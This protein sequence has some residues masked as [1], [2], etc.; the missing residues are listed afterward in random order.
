[1]KSQSLLLIGGGHSHAI[2]LR[3]WAMRYRAE[4]RLKLLSDVEQ[5]PY[6]GMLPGHVAGF[7]THQETHIDLPQLAE[8]SHAQLIRDRAVGLDLQKKQVLCKQRPPIPFDYLSV[9]IGST[10][11]ISNVS[12]AK[13]YAVPAK[14]VPI[15]LQHWNQF[16][17]TVESNPDQPRNLAIVGGGAGGVELALNM[18]QRLQQMTNSVSIHLLQ[19]GK[20]LLPQHGKW[21]RR[22]LQQLLTQRGI[23]LHLGEEVTEVFPDK[24]ICAS[25]M[26]LETEIVFW[27]TQATAPKWIEESGLAT[28]EKG[29][30]LVNEYLQ[31]VS[32]PFVFAAGDIA[33]IQ[34]YP[35]PKAGVFAVRQGK[36][37]FENLQRTILGKPLKPYRPQASYL[38]LIGTGDKS[39]I[40]SWRNLGFHHPL[41]WR[42]K[43]RIDRQFMAKF[44]N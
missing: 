29:F 5:T 22:K 43:D 31:S 19:R 20:A 18:Q 38:S 24:I 33:T 17:A 16:L 6:S 10:P 21:V 27:V 44:S 12:G 2:L 40:A 42:W 3:E 13:D 41:L 26:T 15:F 11:A 23:Q 34:N 37:L 32:H 25:G 28:D 9:D 7:Y 8:F 39:A 4:I 36:P 1:M 35:R 14:P 30:I